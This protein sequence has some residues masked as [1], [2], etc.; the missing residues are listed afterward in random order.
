[1]AGGRAQ[2]NPLSDFLQESE[3]AMK[4]FEPYFE[5]TGANLEY[6]VPMYPTGDEIDMYDYSKPVD[7]DYSTENQRD[8]SSNVFTQKELIV[9]YVIQYY[10]PEKRI[11]RGL[12]KDNE[13]DPPI[14]NQRIDRLVKAVPTATR[15]ILSDLIDYNVEREYPPSM[16]QSLYDFVK[17]QKIPQEDSGVLNPTIDGY[18]YKLCKEGQDRFACLKEIFN[19]NPDAPWSECD[20]QLETC[21]DDPKLVCK[22]DQNGLLIKK[23][24]MEVKLPNEQTCK[25][26]RDCP[27]V[28][29]QNL[30][31]YKGLESANIQLEDGQ[32]V[33][34]R[35]FLISKGKE[36]K[37][38]NPLLPDYVRWG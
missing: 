20:A 29:I 27:D 4:T 31:D 12:D 28:F 13:D 5:G 14:I 8:Y 11:I 21:R 22:Y 6:E 18:Q 1:M 36:E 16:I 3:D 15:E 2:I 26:P 7:Y 34:I 17:T 25:D 23:F 30:K 19:C 10:D 33:P 35:D 38:E 9:R 24:D 32:L 37:D